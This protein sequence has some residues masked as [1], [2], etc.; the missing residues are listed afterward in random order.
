MLDLIISIIHVVHVHARIVLR[1]LMIWEGLV[2]LLNQN[3]KNYSNLYILS[4]EISK[5]VVMVDEA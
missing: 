1:H 3:K 5:R 4:G 2:L